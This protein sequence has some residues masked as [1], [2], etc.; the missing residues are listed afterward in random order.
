VHTLAAYLRAYS[1]RKHVR[2]WSLSAP[3]IVLLMCLPLLSPLRHPLPSQMSDEEISRWAT[4]QAL[5]EQ[6]TFAIEG[7]DFR[8]TG[9]K[10]K[11]AYEY[12]SNQPPTQGLLLAGPYWL[13]YKM[14]LHIHDK[15]ALVEYLL[16]MLGVTLPVA[17][18]AG[19]LYRM[20][21]L[22]E[23]R[24]PW[25][26]GMAL[27]IV[28]GSGMVSY[29]TVLNPYAPAAAL[30]LGS[31]AILVQVCLVRSP[32]RSGGFLTSA[33]FFAALAAAICPAACV[34]T[35][36]FVGVI[37]CMRWRWSLRIGGVLMYGI[38]MVPPIMLHLAL[39]VPITGDWR[40][41]LTSKD[42]YPTHQQ[43]VPRVPAAK[44]TEA[45]DDSIAGPPTVVQMTLN[46]T[47]RLFGAF[48]GS[49][50]L[51]THFPVL[52]FGMIGV[53][54]V[55]HRHWP[56]TTKMLAVATCFGAIV[57][58][59][60][61]AA[62]SVDWRWAMFGNR[63]YVV[64]LPLVMFWSG[65]WLRKSHHPAAWATAGVLLVF[66]V[67]TSMLG[68]TYPMPHDGYDGY[69]VRGVAMKLISSTG[70]EDSPAVAARKAAE[71]ADQVA[72]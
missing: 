21:R 57:I 19:M 6:Q 28:L 22:F 47:G 71:Q 14:G 45:E 51:L 46:F 38:G 67:I 65:A 43:I 37:L 63:W 53:A 30:I 9:Q 33:G 16:T 35:L 31:A 15:P 55:M 49:H 64:F 13:L 58:I 50:G 12:Y 1:R 23:L 4:V 72:E 25:R 27:A 2:P 70:S 32:L 62:M 40:L 36:L 48:L 52:I 54:S 5:V 26:A 8:E 17:A 18:A 39:S 11:V 56:A 7:T 41:G 42:F 10:V 20:G 59:V 61:Y 60:H 34:F 44:T 3:I 29:A 68:A 69:S 24:R 66:S